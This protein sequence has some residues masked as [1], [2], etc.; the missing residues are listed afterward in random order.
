MK[1]KVPLKKYAGLIVIGLMF[2]S[3]LA[4]AASQAFF[5]SG[6]DQV[7]TQ[8]ATATT[9]QGAP[10][11]GKLPGQAIIDYRLAPADVAL[12]VNRGFMV[13][14]YKSSPDC[15]ECEEHKQMLQQVTV[16]SE[17]QSQIILEQVETSG[18]PEL[19]FVSGLGQLTVEEITPDSILDGF[20]NLAINPPLSCAVR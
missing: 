13:V 3:T 10:Q 2:M 9:G 8:G 12:A 11:Q 20:C 19:E 15:V 14:T 17:F 4:F 18:E 5:F 7:Q 1:M 6:S 16:S